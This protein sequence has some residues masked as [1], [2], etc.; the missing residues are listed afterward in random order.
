[1][2]TRRG[3]VPRILF[4]VNVP[5]PASRLLTRHT[6]EFSDQRGWRELKNGDLLAAAERDGFDVFLTADTNLRYQQNLAGWRIA[7]VALST[8]AWPVIRNNAAIV[9]EAVDTGPRE[10]IAT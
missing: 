9:V 8:N 2:T 1:M 3:S 4:D 7:I 6:V 10:H 5:R